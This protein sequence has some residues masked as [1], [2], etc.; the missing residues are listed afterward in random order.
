VSAADGRRRSV[1]DERRRRLGQNFLLPDV[2]D[3]FVAQGS[4]A[5]GEL[6]IEIGAGRGACTHAL[7]RQ[8]VEVVA[9]ER[10]PQ[11]AAALRRELRRLGHAGVRV[12]EGDALALP[13]DRLA[14]GRPYRVLGSLPFG[15]TTALLRHLFDDVGRGPWRA[16]LIVQWEVA[17]KRA[18]VPP[19]TLVSTTWAPWWTFELMR[20]IPAR[21]FRPVP[22]VDA[23]VLRVTRRTPALLPERLAG[24]FAE[25]V[26]REWG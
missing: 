10:D 4:F 6:V 20:R 22:A 5:P 8:G 17:R 9:L 21:S 25:F 2:A 7:A 16:D 11:W 14:G 15:V 12:V 19:T 24:G 23:G 13:L 18:A 26:R 1:R 3:S